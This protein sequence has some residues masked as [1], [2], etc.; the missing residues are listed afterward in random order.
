MLILFFKI[1]RVV[2]LISDKVDFRENN[3]TGNKED[4]IIIIKES[5]HQEDIISLNVSE[6][7][8]DT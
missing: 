8:K 3:I 5:S 1:A 4:N 6:C 2:S 7:N